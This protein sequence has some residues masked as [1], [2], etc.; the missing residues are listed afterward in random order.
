MPQIEIYFV[1]ISPENWNW[2]DFQVYY[3]DHDDGASKSWVYCLE[4]MINNKDTP[5]RNCKLAR[6]L[7]DEHKES[8]EDSGEESGEQSDEK[9][10]SESQRRKRPL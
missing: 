10:E 5:S 4:I 7:L 8:G 2:Q 6:Q 3:D 9:Q 1:N